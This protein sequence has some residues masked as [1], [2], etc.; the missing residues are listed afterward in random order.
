M[1]T[2][3]P[4]VSAVFTEENIPSGLSAFIVISVAALLVVVFIVG[5][6]AGTMS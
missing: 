1:T 5:Y 2:P 4:D 6:A 3:R